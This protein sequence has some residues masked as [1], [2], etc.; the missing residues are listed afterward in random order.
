MAVNVVKGMT[1][2]QGMGE[3]KAGLNALSLGIK[4][5]SFHSVPVLLREG[6]MKTLLAGMDNGYGILVCCMSCQ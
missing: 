1:L 4:M 3:C 6:A 2:K 5:D